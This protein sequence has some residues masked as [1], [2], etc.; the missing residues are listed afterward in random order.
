MAYKLVVKEEASLE[1]KEAYFYY[2]KKKIGLGT[3]FLN[4]LGSY[5][6]RLRKSPEHFPK[7]NNFFREAVIK[8]FPYMIIFRIEEDEVYVLSVFNTWRDP[9]R[10]P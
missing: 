6:E 3:L 5:L 7:K 10:K 4:T 8:Q 2:E 9:K 1:I